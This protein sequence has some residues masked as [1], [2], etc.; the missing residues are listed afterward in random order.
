MN[1]HLEEYLFEYI[2]TK[3]ELRNMY[4]KSY[5][6]IQLF[7][8]GLNPDIEKLKRFCKEKRKTIINGYWHVIT[9]F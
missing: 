1:L 4:D 7:Q 9:F 8:C 3:Q 6:E 2:N 5:N